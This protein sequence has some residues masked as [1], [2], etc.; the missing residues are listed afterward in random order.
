[1]RRVPARRRRGTLQ[2]YF[3]PGAHNNH[4]PEFL[5]FQAI[6]I[7]VAIVVLL[8][9]IALGLQS[10]VIRSPSPQVGAVVAAVLVDLANTDRSREELPKL[11]V[12]PLLEEAAQMKANDMAALGYFAHRSPEGRD[13]WYWFNEVGYD[14]RFAGENLAVYFADSVE[15]EKAWMNSPTHRANIMSDKFT[16]VG[17]ALAGGSYQGNDTTFVVQ[18]FGAPAQASAAAIASASATV[19]TSSPVAGASARALETIVESDT[20]IA[21]KRGGE[22]APAVASETLAAISDKAQPIGA[23]KDGDA[24]PNPLW[25]VIAAPKTTLQYV[26]ASVAAL[27]LLVLALIFMAGIRHLHVP[28]VVRGLGL[29]ALIGLLLW[30]STYLSGSL[31]IL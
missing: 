24:S 15:V 14:F 29:L 17:I 22:P 5:E 3:V 27:V 21:V 19:D 31:L 4:R 7:N 23:L 20:F 25:R 2:H 6:A 16:E 10:L 13:P 30:S 11:V 1:M 12:N 9:L 26:Y 28:S 8:F 18:M